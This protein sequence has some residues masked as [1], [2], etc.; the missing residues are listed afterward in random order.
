[1]A[2]SGKEIVED[3]YTSDFYQDIEVLKK[4]LHPQVE[5]SWYGTT[6][7]K[8]LN[9]DE[10]SAISHELAHSFESLRAEVENVISEKGKTAIQFTYYVRTIENPEE[11][12]P[13]AHFMAIWELKGDKLY[14]G[15]QISQL[16]EEVNEQPWL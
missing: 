5:L 14:R 1:M 10:I 11:E 15:V 3:F 8:K 12:M 7:L 6:G 4:F 9:L 13:L 2:S 16:G